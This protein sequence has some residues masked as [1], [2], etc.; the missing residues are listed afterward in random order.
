MT[1]PGKEK[2]NHPKEREREREREREG[3]RRKARLADHHR[4]SQNIRLGC[5]NSRH[6]TSELHIFTII[7]SFLS[8]MFNLL[9][10]NIV[11]SNFSC[12]FSLSLSLSLNGISSQTTQTSDLNLFRFASITFSSFG[13]LFFLPA[14]FL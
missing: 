14:F 12:I 2:K 8:I 5:S 6:Q 7:F 9:T 4:K 1:T 10:S 3:E 13:I 11:T